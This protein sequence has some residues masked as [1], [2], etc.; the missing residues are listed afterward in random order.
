MGFGSKQPLVGEKRCVTTLITAAKE[1]R[2]AAEAYQNG[3]TRYLTYPNSAKLAYIV[4]IQDS[5]YIAG[6]QIVD[7]VSVGLILKGV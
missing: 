2:Y 7:T 4:A 6:Y 5:D 3:T 1:T